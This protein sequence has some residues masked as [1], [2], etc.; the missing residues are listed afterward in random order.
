M[1]NYDVANVPVSLSAYSAFVKYI[2]VDWSL[3]KKK[4]KSLTA[5]INDFHWKSNH[6]RFY[7]QWTLDVFLNKKFNKMQFKC[8]ENT[9]CLLFI[10][11]VFSLVL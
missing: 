3:K 5:E 7:F 4:K 9:I 1:F 10:L 2:D 8:N 6:L 11:S